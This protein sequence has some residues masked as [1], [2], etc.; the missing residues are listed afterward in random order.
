LHITL[1]IA[2]FLG[3]ALFSTALSAQVVY[4]WVDQD[5]SLKFSDQ[6]PRHVKADDLKKIKVR[7][8]NSFKTVKEIAKEQAKT[9]SQQQQELVKMS[10]KNCDIANKNLKL[11]NSFNNISQIDANGKEVILT[12]EQKIEQI[13]LTKKQAEIYCV[14]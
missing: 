13:N 9:P 3:L 7:N 4:Q 10:Q 12:S 8:N 6:M 1:L 5:G 14:K 2:P 11:L